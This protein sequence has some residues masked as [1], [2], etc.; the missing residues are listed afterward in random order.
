MASATPAWG[1]SRT[2][3]SARRIILGLSHNDLLWCITA[4]SPIIGS[5]GARWS[6]SPTASCRIAIRS[7]SRV[8]TANN[9]EQGASLE[10]SLKASIREIDGV[11]TYLVATDNE[12]GMAKDTKAA[13][14][15]V[16]YEATI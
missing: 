4:R 15:M 13:K 9:L 16:L 12:L 6:G 7:C 1:R 11:F 3:I 5:C 10:D 2:S 14:P 8:Y